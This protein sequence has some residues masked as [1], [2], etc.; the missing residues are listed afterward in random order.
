[1]DGCESGMGGVNV[2]IRRWPSTYL[3][4]ILNQKKKQQVKIEKEEWG[5]T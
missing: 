3:K 4:A 5:H 1:M 2:D